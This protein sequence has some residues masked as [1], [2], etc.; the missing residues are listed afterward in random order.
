[1]CRVKMSAGRTRKGSKKSVR[2]SECARTAAAAPL[3]VLYAV[4]QG[5]LATGPWVIGQDLRARAAEA[6]LALCP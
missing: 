3:W 4:V 5:T 6:M 2:E 1:M